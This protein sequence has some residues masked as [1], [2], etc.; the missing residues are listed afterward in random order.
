[1][2]PSNRSRALHA[3]CVL[4]ALASGIAS[5]QPTPSMGSTARPVGAHV[6]GAMRDDGARIDGIIVS[7]DNDTLSLAACG[8]CAASTIVAL[9][10]VAGLE[11]EGRRPHIIGAH[12]IRNALVGGFGGAAAGAGIGYLVA[13]QEIRTC[14]G[15]LCGLTFLLVPAGG[16]AGAG[17][18]F[19]GGVVVG[20]SE[21]QSYWAPFPSSPAPG[22]RGAGSLLPAVTDGFG[23]QL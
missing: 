7:F 21:R 17:V 1:M 22:D 10:D 5:G 2:I 20:L 6:R 9:N 19:V 8:K 18:G 15:D 12:I 3:G 23:Q 11:I 16:V 13:E 14:R 4:V